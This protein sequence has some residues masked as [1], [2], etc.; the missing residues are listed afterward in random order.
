MNTTT[1]CGGVQTNPQEQVS[2]T[3]TIFHIKLLL[4]MLIRPNIA[5]NH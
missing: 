2:M 5:K 3:K 4:T 1:S